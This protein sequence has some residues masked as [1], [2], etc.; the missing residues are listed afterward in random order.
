MDAAAAAVIAAARLW[1]THAYPYLASALFAMRVVA[2]DGIGTVAVDRSWRL[3]VDPAL[4]RARSPQSLG[5]LLVHHCGHL[6][7]DH[8]GRA[9]D[10]GVDD[11]SAPRWTAACDAE[12]NDDLEAA[13]HRLEPGD[14]TPRRLGMAEGRL[15]E[16]YYAGIDAP[17]SGCGDHGSGVH[18]LDRPW[19]RPPGADTIRPQEIDLIRTRV[20]QDVLVA[21]RAG[22]VAGG[23]QRWAEKVTGSTV[24]WR[25]LFAGEVRSG[26]ASVAGQVDYTYQRRSRRQAASHDVVLPALRRPTPE[27]AV[28]VDTSGSMS[29]AHLGR[30]L[31]EVE[32][33]IR[34]LGVHDATVLSVDASV[35]GQ[36]RHRRADT[37]TMAGGGGTDMA[38]GI[39]AAAALRPRPAVIVVLTDGY[40]DWPDRRPALSRV[41]IGLITDAPHA[42]PP[43]PPWARTVVI[44]TDELGLVQ[45]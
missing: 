6:L 40:T 3:Y 27:V 37:V 31:A 34:R 10:A 8:G 15:A 11:S 45:A 5:V 2:A 17:P 30:A 41:V 29:E 4:V 14:I 13:G 7:R 33:V 9:H 23:W 38:A 36:A 19:E 28:V 35:H 44:P 18:G 39:A 12:I 20:A 26:V 24:D 1:A 43:A 16:E 25:R 42:P 32:G 21:S 22:D